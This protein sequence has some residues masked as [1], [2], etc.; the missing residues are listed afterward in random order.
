[1]E[2]SGRLL[3]TALLGANVEAFVFGEDADVIRR[4]LP[5]AVTVSSTMREAL[6][7]AR[8]RARAGDTVLLSPAC[9]SFDEFSGYAERGDAF[10]EAVREGSDV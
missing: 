7:Q 6:G 9:A 2:F 4:A 1:M 5:A 10:A 3:A 8:A